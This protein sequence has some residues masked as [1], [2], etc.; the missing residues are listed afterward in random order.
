MLV[1][2]LVRAHWEVG[3]VNSVD[4]GEPVEERLLGQWGSA[5]EVAYESRRLPDHCRHPNPLLSR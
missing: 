5:G 4:A 2:E 3:M 1:V